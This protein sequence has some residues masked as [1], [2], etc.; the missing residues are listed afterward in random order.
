VRRNWRRYRERKSSW[1]RR[2]GLLGCFDGER[3]EKKGERKR[4]RN[5]GGEEGRWE[6]RV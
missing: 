5:E 1:E 3:R 6:R 4:E 2:C